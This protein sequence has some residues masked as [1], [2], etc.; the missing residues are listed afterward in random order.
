MGQEK[1]RDESF[2]VQAKEP[3]RTDY[4]QNFKQMPAPHWARKMLCIIV[5]NRRTVSPEFL[6]IV[7]SR[8]SKMAAYLGFFE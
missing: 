4:F 3:L 1:G 7:L 5:P 2:Q 8:H 6:F